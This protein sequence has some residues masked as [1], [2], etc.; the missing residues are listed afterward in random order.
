M[1]LYQMYRR[2]SIS[3][4]LPGD[5]FVGSKTMC[6]PCDPSLGSLEDI[7]PAQ[8]Y[9]A[10]LTSVVFFLLSFVAIYSLNVTYISSF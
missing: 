1:E 6:D 5:K 7:S 8:I 9:R 10:D 3:E 2:N 4:E